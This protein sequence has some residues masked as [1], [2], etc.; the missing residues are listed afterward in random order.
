[1][2]RSSTPSDDQQQVQHQAGER[3]PAGDQ[4]A[5]ARRPVGP[6]E[7]QH[8]GEDQHG[9]RQRL[10]HRMR[11]PLEPDRELR[12]DLAQP[13]PERRL[14][15]PAG[16]PGPVLPDRER[17]QRQPAQPD[18]A[19]RDLHRAPRRYV[20]SNSTPPRGRPP[21]SRSSA[22]PARAPTR[23]PTRRAT[24][25]SASHERTRTRAATRSTATRAS[26]RSAP[27]ASTRSATGCTRSAPRRSIPA[28]RE[29]SFA[30]APYATGTTSTP[31]SADSERRPVSP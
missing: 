25:A 22:W 6:G 28:R 31:H 27:P 21:G 14:G 23:A 11:R 12:H 2:I 24:A 9:N 19:D 16:V 29:I 18:D 1:M 4:R 7:H 8:R 13:A 26:R 20:H 30:P 10:E 3:D 15:D 17:N 5:P